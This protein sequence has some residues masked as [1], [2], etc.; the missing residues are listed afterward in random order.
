MLECKYCIEWRSAAREDTL[1]CYD[2]TN[3]LA[4]SWWWEK[5][6]QGD[7]LLHSS[8]LTQS[9]LTDIGLCIPVAYVL[10]RCSMAY[11]GTLQ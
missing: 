10:Q 6:S 8:M 1:F 3:H 2:H 5:D 4:R 9:I 7:P 11:S